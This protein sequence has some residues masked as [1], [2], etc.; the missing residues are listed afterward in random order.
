MGKLTVAIVIFA[1]MILG[2]F[3]LSK[4]LITGISS[5]F[6]D[7]VFV[8]GIL[9]AALFVLAEKFNPKRN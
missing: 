9:T 1:A 3:H 2:L 8:G 5:D 4:W 7:G 6:G